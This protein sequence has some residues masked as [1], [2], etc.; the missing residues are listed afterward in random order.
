MVPSIV[1]VGGFAS[2]L[3]VDLE[4]MRRSSVLLLLS[5][6]KLFCIQRVSEDRQDSMWERG[7]LW[8]DLVLR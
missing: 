4:P 1:S 7:G 5:F 8:G 2:L 6:R 3:R